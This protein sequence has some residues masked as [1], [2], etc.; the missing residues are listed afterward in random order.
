MRK[1]TIT[2]I[3][4]TAKQF[5]EKLYKALNSE[6][7]TYVNSCFGSDCT[8]PDILEQ[9]TT[10]TQW[11]RT[12]AAETK[13]KAAIA[14]EQGKPLWGWDCVNLVKGILYGWDAIVDDPTGRG[15]ARYKNN[16][17]PDCTIED[18]YYNYCTEQSEDWNKEPEIGEFVVYS[19]SF[20]HCGVYVGDGK[21][22]EATTKWESKV[23]ESYCLNLVDTGVMPA[24]PT[25][26]HARRWW[27][28]AKL[29]WI[30][31]ST[32]IK[33]VETEYSFMC[34]CPYCGHKIEING[35][36]QSTVRKYTVQTGDNICKIAREQLH[37]ESRWKE[38]AELSGLQPPYILH[39]GDVL[40]LPVV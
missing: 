2:M 31:Y 21:I 3:I 13:N 28:H 11:D 22:I 4:Y 27:V 23:L 38:I 30:D 35:T 16:G 32:D 9:Y 19:G 24:P 18:M 26:A 34:V 8:N 20:G 39:T 29:P 17:V 12:H 36:Q 10:E 14:I 5:V 33:T 37:D 15:G 25:G 7:Q 1:G 40:T 6:M